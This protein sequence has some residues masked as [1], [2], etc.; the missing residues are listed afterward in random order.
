MDTQPGNGTDVYAAVARRL[1]VMESVPRR[2]DGLRSALHDTGLVLNNPERRTYAQL[3][4]EDAW[5]WK[6]MDGSR[7]IRDL[8][9]VYFQQYRSLAPGRVLNLVAML[10][11]RGLLATDPVDVWAAVA[12]A[13]RPARARW[14]TKLWGIVSGRTALRA[15]HADRA[16]GRVYR[17]VGRLVFARPVLWLSLALTL[18]GGAA[19]VYGWLSGRATPTTRLTSVGAVM[20]AAYAIQFV[21]LAAHEL[22]HGV[23][24][25]HRGCHVIGFGLTLFYGIPC[26]FVDTTDAWMA[27]RRGRI[28]VS[29]AGPYSGF[30]LSGALALVALFLGP[31]WGP[32]LFQVVF[33]LN[34]TAAFNL[35]PF[36]EMDGYYMLVDWLGIPMLRARSMGFLRRG[37]LPRWRSR[38]PLTRLETVYLWYGVAAVGTSIVFTVWG[39]QFWYGQA[40]QLLGPVWA[41]GAGAR[42]VILLI[43]LLLL[44]PLLYNF[45]RRAA[46][47]RHARRVT[48]WLLERRPSRLFDAR[49]LVRCGIVPDGDERAAR[50][51]AARMRRASYRPGAL[52]VRE[53]APGREFFVI[54]R[55]AAAVVKGPDEAEVARLGAADYFGEL[56][57]VE[58]APRSASVR[59]LTRLDVLVMGK[60]DFDRLAAEHVELSA[61]VDRMLTADELARF[62]ALSHLAPAQLRELRPHLARE[63]VAAGAIIFSQGDP[64]DRFYLIEEGQVDVVRDGERVLLLGPGGSFG[65]TALL[66]ARP[67][68]ATVR[69]MTPATLYSMDRSGFDAFVRAVVT[70]GGET[71]WTAGS[72]AAQP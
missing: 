27:D 21:I 71:G 68:N 53:G 38:T 32:A 65:E 39:L 48:H 19:F 23:E 58:H 49:L 47:G 66:D 63:P 56:A 52:V 35:L 5:L 26:L 46:V 33:L 43:G 20:V 57:L 50:E 61:S 25:K 13:V 31:P 37:L 17:A 22:A 59:A 69:A 36:V 4:P 51:M 55:G 6:Q 11:A 15:P 45:A 72:A 70:R 7:S 44:L 16:F 3:G 24:C 42:V 67:R 29:W 8:M 18:A 28:L 30:I 60:G 12:A 9:V 2:R 34:F 41:G 10:G 62:P 1:D 64:G 54:R 40:R 14:R